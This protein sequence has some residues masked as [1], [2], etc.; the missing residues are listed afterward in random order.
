MDL[1]EVQMDAVDEFLFGGDADLAQHGAR[2]FTEEILHQIQP[3]SRACRNEQNEVKPLWPC[4]QIS[5]SLPRDVG[6]MVVQNQAQRLEW[7]GRQTSS[8]VR[9]SMKSLLLC[10]L[11]TISVTLPVCRSRPASSDTVPSRLYS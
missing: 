9:N 10:V 2:H 4:R 3:G 1:P 5:L 6:R 7:R 11:F 8:L